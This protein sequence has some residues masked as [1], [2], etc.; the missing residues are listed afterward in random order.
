MSCLLSRIRDPQRPQRPH[1]SHVIHWSRASYRERTK[2][3]MKQPVHWSRAS[4]RATG[5]QPTECI[6]WQP[7]IFGY[8]R[9]RH[10]PYVPGIVR[11]RHRPYVPG[12]VRA[13]HRPS[14]APAPPHAPAPLPAPPGRG[15][16]IAARSRARPGNAAA[17]MPERPWCPR[18]GA[19]TPLRPRVPHAP[20]VRETGRRVRA[21]ARPSPTPTAGGGRKGGAEMAR[22]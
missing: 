7:A 20:R 19:D 4:Y 2:S 5:S 6:R 14:Q 3:S 18:P 16:Q 12:I 11:A 1:A 21:A 10:R 15:T 8:V 13:R 22:D 9:A 17:A